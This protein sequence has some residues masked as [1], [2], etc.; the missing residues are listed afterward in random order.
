MKNFIFELLSVILCCV[1]FQSF[2]QQSINTAGHKA[3][4]NGNATITY[5][6][7]QTFG[8]LMNSGVQIPFEIQV[9]TEIP[10]LEELGITCMVYP[11]P[12]V[13]NIYL[14][15]SELKNCQYQIFDMNGT[16]LKQSN[17]IDNLT[18]IPIKNFNCKTMIISVISDNK[19]IK[20]FKIIKN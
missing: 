19:K 2:S 12:A 8:T 16:L 18:T 11:N 9:I 7:G 3:G 15:I 17:V 5:T 6:I 1:A 20:S 13:K 14:K 10:E 4:G